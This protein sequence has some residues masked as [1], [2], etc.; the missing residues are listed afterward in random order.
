MCSSDLFAHGRTIERLQGDGRLLMSIVM[1]VGGGIARLLTLWP[2]T[3]PNVSRYFL[4]RAVGVGRCAE[5]VAQRVTRLRK[6][7]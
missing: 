2:P 1:L 5:I 4:N 3:S 6:P 7:R